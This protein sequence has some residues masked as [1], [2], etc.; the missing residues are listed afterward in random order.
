M[1]IY[2]F[3]LLF[4]FFVYIW[5]FVRQQVHMLQLNSYRNERYIEWLK[6]QTR[7]EASYLMFGLII[8]NFTIGKVMPLTVFYL[9]HAMLFLV[10][11]LINKHEAEKKPLVFT[12]RIRRLLFSLGLL[13]S[14]IIVLL[15]ILL[16]ATFWMDIPLILGIINLLLPG[17]V[18]LTNKVN[19]PWEKQIAKGYTAE[20][21]Q[22]LAS[23]PTLKVIGVTGS[24]GKTS[25]KYVLNQL[26][27]VKYQVLMTPESFNTPM[28][29][30]RTI[31]EQ[32]NGT[33][34]IFIAEMGARN[35]GDIK[36]ICDIVSPDLGIISSVGEQ[37][38]ETFKSIDNVI[39]TKFELAQAVTQKGGTM[40]LNFSNSHIRQHSKTGNCI[41]YGVVST[42]KDPAKVYDLWA[43]QLCSGPQGSTFNI[44]RPSGEKVAFATRLLG[45]HNVLNIVAAVAVALSL[46]ITI[47]QLVPAV[48]RLEPV[49]H[50]LQ[51]LKGNG[52]YQIIDDA[53]NSN[54]QGAEEAVKTLGTFSGF[55]V[56]ITP[57][58][59]ELGTKEEDLNRQFGRQAAKYCDYLI[60]VGANRAAPI[61]K[62]AKHAGFSEDKIYVAKDIYDALSMADTLAA[63]LGADEGPMYV[64]LENDLPDNYLE[65]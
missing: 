44:C 45:E 58:M 30:V 65:K 21:K 56:L 10:L 15:C 60:L 4:G 13:C 6:K 3:L 14:L 23:R 27:A 25:T 18:L 50:R 49:P 11:R 52:R 28:G 43:D 59:V 32:L 20:A 64:L 61:K 63:T 31:R 8:I 47:E 48:Y 46:G 57:G 53:Y 36:E 16:K 26:L 19:G 34:E 62:G 51:L 39:T 55:R 42:E 40:F 33:H 37:H 54:P 22:L 38:L 35:I 24:Y 5:P 7:R 2:I 29:V 9:F 17:L 41:R 12:W 1:S